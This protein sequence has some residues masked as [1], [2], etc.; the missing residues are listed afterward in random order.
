MLTVPLT[1]TLGSK[2][3][4]LAEIHASFLKLEC[5]YSS[6]TSFMA[7]MS[8]FS[9]QLSLAAIGCQGNWVEKYPK[10]KKEC[11]DQLVMFV[12]AAAMEEVVGK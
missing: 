3:V 8:H 1:W 12:V 2:Q 9:C 7:N 10:T 4:C 6:L 5:K 11:H